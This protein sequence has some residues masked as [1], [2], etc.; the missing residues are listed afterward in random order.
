MGMAWAGYEKTA[1]RCI[2]WILF[3][4]PGAHP[5]CPLLVP[6]LYV[7]ML[8]AP[9]LSLGDINRQEPPPPRT[10]EGDRGEGEKRG[11]KSGNHKPSSPTRKTASHPPT[12]PRQ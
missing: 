4:S 2:W 5:L 8:S 12:A 6:C 9:P 1:A 11:G 10:H 3:I 7:C